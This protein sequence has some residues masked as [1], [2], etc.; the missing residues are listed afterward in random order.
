MAHDWDKIKSEYVEGILDAEGNITF[1][2]LQVLTDRHGVSQSTLRK[3]SALED[4]T[5]EKNIFRTKLERAHREKKLEA[6]AGKSA[7]FDGSIFR[8]AEI[9]VKHIQAHF[10]RANE[11]F[12]NS[13]GQEMMNMSNLD[14]LSKSLE[15]YQRIGRLALGEPTEITGGHENG[16]KYYVIQEIIS[17]PE[18]AERIREN[19][20]QRIGD[21]VSPE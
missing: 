19:Y 13:D 5:T 17:N 7:E 1:P 11:Q 10:I 12:R 14:N 20:R 2:T 4:W 8:I 3:K 15:R 21:R 9:A 18:H 16:E 6:L